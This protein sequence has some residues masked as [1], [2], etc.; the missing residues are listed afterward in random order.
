M[1]KS[2]RGLALV[3]GFLG[4]TASCFAKLAFQSDL[5]A[6]TWVRGTCPRVAS[7]ALCR[8]AEL[9]PRGI[10]LAAMILSNALMLGSFLKGMEESGS[11]AGTAL[12]TASNFIVSAA[13][14]Y[15]LWEDRFPL[16][17]LLGFGMVVAGA[18]LLSTVEVK[19]I[20]KR[21]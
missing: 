9:V 14:G 4:A 15:L 7:V 8:A 1:T 2:I 10:C 20:E 18:M 6:A 16:A 11:V 5:N 21:D 13:Y 3:S 19:K 17:W 12:A